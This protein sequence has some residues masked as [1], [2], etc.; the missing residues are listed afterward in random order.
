MK[1]WQ[2]QVVVSNNL[3]TT[4]LK[5]DEK[6]ISKVNKTEETLDKYLSLKSMTKHGKVTYRFYIKKSV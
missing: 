1:T 6:L 4:L 2:D 3:E 5:I